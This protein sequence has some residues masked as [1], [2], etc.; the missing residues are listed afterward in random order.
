MT[1]LRLG[2]LHIATALLLAAALIGCGKG[3]KE[4]RVINRADG[5]FKAGEYDKAK[6]EYLNLLRRDR[7][8]ATAIQQ[9]G[10]IWFEEGALLQ[11]YPYLLEAR[12]L[13]PDNLAIRTK[14]ASVLASLGEIDEA[15]EE[16]TAVLEQSP[17]QEEALLVLADTVGSDEDVEEVQ[18]QLRKI[19]EGN[20]VSFHLAS[21]SLA[22]RKGDLP[23]ALS[24]LQ[25]ALKLV[26]QSARVHLAMAN[27]YS[28]RQDW[29]KAGEEF[30]LAAEVS[31]ARSAAR[32][33]YAEFERR[34]GKAE[35]ATLLLKDITMQAPDYFPAWCLL[36][37]IALSQKKF[38]ESLSL[39]ENVL[40]R[41]PANLEGLILQ[42][43]AW[44][45]RGETKKAIEGL[46]SL[47]V[48][49]PN[50]PL[51]NY[52]LARAYLADNNSAEAAAALNDAIAGKP[53]YAEAILLRGELDLRNGN[54]PLVVPAILGLLKKHPGLVPARVLLAEAYR[55]SGRLDDAAASIRDQIRS[56]LQSPDAYF[57]LGLILRQQQKV[58]EAGAAFEHALELTPENLPIIEQLVE[59]D[60]SRKDFEAA[61][62]RARQQLAKE[63]NL[64][65]AYFLEGK[66]YFAQ[67]EWDRAEAALHKAL[68][69]DPNFSS[70]FDLLIS[71][72]V[73]T[74]KLD[75]AIKELQTVLSK[76][77]DNVRAVTS[78]ALIYD[79]MQD[80]AKAAD[81]YEKL[82]LIRPDSAE[83]MNNLAYIY[84][85]HLNQIDKA[86]EL[87]H[88]A[89]ALRPSDPLIADTL[90][91]TLYK[92]ADYQEAQTLLRESAERLPEAAEVQFHFGV[93]SYMMA[94]SNAAQKAFQRALGAEH[95]FPAKAEAQ[96]RL[97]FLENGAKHE[98]STDQLQELLRKQPDDVIAW[99]R[100]GGSYE[101]TGDV[102]RA[103]S[104]YEEA[105][106]IN[107][108][109]LPAAVKLAELNAGPLRNKDM[110]FSFAK[111][112]RDLAP[113]DAQV[114]GLL[115]GIVHQLGN[116]SWA[117]SL[118]QESARKLS[119]DAKILHDYA[120]TAYS[121]G[122]VSD[123]RRI[124]QRA[125]EVQPDPKTAEDAKSF[126]AMTALEDTP[127]GLAMSEPEIRRILA[128]DGA[129]VPA[130]LAKAD[131][132]V[133]RGDAG[134]AVVICNEILRRYPDFA[135][136]QKR[137]ASLYLN[138]PARIDEAYGLALKATNT[139]PDDPE[140]AQTLGELSYKRKEFPYAIQ[141]FQESARK[142]PLRGKDLYY[143]GM[144]QLRMS[145]DSES[146]K[147]L[148][149]AL[150]AGLQEPMSRDAKAVLTELQKR[151]GL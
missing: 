19:P 115:G 140:L 106:K 30:R 49:F 35:E 28:L 61:M 134:S 16:A 4:T 37:E 94:D 65:G 11:A 55:A 80:Y 138:D 34:I 132:Q 24:D 111:R 76:S 118:L 42:A 60:I 71:T 10:L 131:L 92:N 67:G 82:L 63:P 98:L 57:R 44:L 85:E 33:K 2:C 91:W 120:W 78:L 136:A 137:L 124:M 17:G 32:L 73:S 97:A 12:E 116:F 130:L 43:E 38:D 93:A 1:T 117:Y 96:R 95:D 25:A 48:A 31:P 123:A 3:A 86:Y 99:M 100:L 68:D 142:K 129:Y 79:K 53:D 128:M 40:A 149:K 26:P 74:K 150:A 66:I 7:K 58:D 108:E 50:V 13:V 6:I 127:E 70:A 89:R 9:L 47:A 122:K 145:Q 21:A 113:N 15:K 18:E 125:L 110:A 146:R 77:P 109:L 112:A 20:D 104:A 39:L 51:I 81:T 141:W 87:S 62:Q 126:L 41:D 114:A 29:D 22:V 101:N 105:L 133:Q 45:G 147:T 143:L 23:Y 64:P 8:N 103:A 90:G 27:V 148:E 151:Q 135:P 75:Q 139:L 69:L 5:F 52:H 119:G 46:Q 14:L 72:Y 54:A 36:A 144:S 121:L 102:V 83:A 107:S 59:L 88:K 84:A 56:G